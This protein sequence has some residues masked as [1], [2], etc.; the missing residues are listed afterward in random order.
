M[1][2]EDRLFIKERLSAKKGVHNRISLG[3]ADFS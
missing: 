3:T 2:R 1:E